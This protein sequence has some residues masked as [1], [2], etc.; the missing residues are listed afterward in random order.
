L[1]LVQSINRMQAIKLVISLSLLGGLVYLGNTHGA[2]KP[3]LP[4][5]ARLLDPFAGVWQQA[6][7]TAVDLEPGESIPG[8]RG[9][10]VFDERGVPHVFANS[11]ADALFIQGYLHARD[12]LF[13]MDLTVRAAEG[14]LA[15]VLGPDLL[16]RD[17]LQRRK[18]MRV[19]AQRAVGAWLQ[20]PESAAVVAAYTSGV[21][22]YIQALAPKDYPVEYKL[23][24][25]T[26]EAWSAYKCALMSKSMA[27]TLC[28]RNE[29]VGMTNIRTALGDRLFNHLYPE[30]NPKQSPVIATPTTWPGPAAPEIPPAE[31]QGT[32][33]SSLPFPAL[34]QSPEGI[35]SNNWALAGSKT[36]T[37]FPLLGND[38]HLGLTLPSIWY[39]IQLHTPTN[40]C[41]GVSLPALP[42]I[43]I[44]FNEQSAWGI[45]NVGHD[46]VD[47]YT[48]NWTD[49]T[50]TAYWLDG[51][52]TAPTWITDT[53]YVRGQTEP[54][55]E[56]TPWTYFGPVVYDQPAA[57]NYN[58]AMR[59]VVH[60]PPPVAGLDNIE[61]FLKLTA[62]SDLATYREA[63]RGFDNP[64]S[65]VVYANQHNDI[66]MTVTG[67]LPIR[68]PGQGRFVQDGSQRA[69][70]WSGFIPFVEIPREENP[71]RQFVASANQNSTDLTYPYYYL[72]S[73]EDYRGRYINRQL[74]G[75]E[76]ATPQDMMD[77]QQDAYSV[78]A[79]EAVP[80]MLTALSGQTR[81]PR[82]AQGLAL[83]DSWDF[84]Y[85][86]DAAA[87]VLFDA[88]YDSLYQLTFDEIY[89]L[90]TPQRP[91]AFPK[92]WRLLALL[93]QA[94]A[95]P[96][97]DRQTTPARETA[98]DLIQLA[99][100]QACAAVMPAIEEGL[101]WS[102]QRNTRIPHLARISGFGSDLIHA[103]GARNTPNAL[104]A[105]FGPSWRMVVSLEQPLRAW[106]VLPGGPSG[107]VGSPFYSGGIAEWSA[108][109]YFELH[110]YDQPAAVA[111]TA[112][113]VF[114][115]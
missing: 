74:A 12:R 104:S 103:N 79:E 30:Y 78:Q 111:A 2:I 105:S 52:A 98:A 99:F 107:N 40:S 56:K 96:V 35:G 58:L 48:V 101:T 39:E 110:C 55:L 65:N 77:L 100:V 92:T 50:R 63:L 88:W 17:R 66:A 5:L 93:D 37:G 28:F 82:Q 19:A 34:P 102:Q 10:V 64:A 38:P 94:P 80:I 24:G 32:L 71:T 112:R 87:P 1:V 113:L 36:A 54:V 57:V 45:T 11:D 15:E 42:G 14:R 84:R 72:G 108:G 68:Q 86:A 7:R 75:G 83:V 61:S 67:H 85:L 41:Y 25:F 76:Q 89:T 8:A 29:D 13:Q 21:N 46:V 22:A 69:N 26:P 3:Q 70:L 60:D 109:E 114:G 4:G 9:E 31:K 43:L 47:W 97:F 106:G 59:W 6:V 91:V 53:I 18:G 20:N 49:T 90:N 27:E 95:D 23:L 16:E 73:F 44:G 62:N 115:H 51:V 33:S 81:T